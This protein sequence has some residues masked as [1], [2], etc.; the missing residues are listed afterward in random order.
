MAG[1]FS[2]TIVK[3]LGSVQTGTLCTVDSTREETK[4]VADKISSSL[5]KR[6]KCREPRD[7]HLEPDLSYTFE[8]CSVADLLV[9]VA[10]SQSKLKLSDRAKRY[11]EGSDGNIRTVVGLN[12]ND[13]YRGGRNATF[14][15]WR[16]QL[17]GERWNCGTAETQVKEFGL[18][19]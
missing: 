4:N 2:D 19:N 5:A 15:I 12:M 11:I 10:W 18:P 1:R 7:D 17:V 16:A 9:E 3:W 6:V 13:I 8:D 14:S